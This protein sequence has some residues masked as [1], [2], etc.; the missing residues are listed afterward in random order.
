MRVTRIY[1]ERLI[2]TG[3]FEN[4][5][6]GVDV[7]VDPDD[8]PE[9]ALAWAREFVLKEYHTACSAIPVRPLG[10]AIVPKL[11]DDE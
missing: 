3:R 1:F 7:L 5:R 9:R 10:P 11:D 4:E 6:I 8:T 2:P